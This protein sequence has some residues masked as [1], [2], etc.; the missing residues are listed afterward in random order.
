MPTPELCACGHYDR[1]HTYNADYDL[2]SCSG[3]TW[4]Y[5][6][7]VEGD[8]DGVEVRCQCSGFAPRQEEKTDGR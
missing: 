4:A 3:N 8:G 2:T 5:P 6:D 7:D 1:E